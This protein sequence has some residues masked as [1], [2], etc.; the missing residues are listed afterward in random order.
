MATTKLERID[1]TIDSLTGE[2]LA[3]HTKIID[4][5]PMEQEPD[6]VKFYIEDMGRMMGL[7]D[8]H[9]SILLYVAASV[10][11][12]GTLSM[13]NYRKGRIACTLGCSKRSI[14]NAISE[15]VKQGILVRIAR[16]EY[17]LDPHLFARGRWV[18]IRQRRLK[19]SAKITYSPTTGRTIETEVSEDTPENAE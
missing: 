17:E 9:R 2:I 19:F 1:R 18:D 11:Y 5:K 3:E 8:G 10:S 15:F 6:Y 14:D 4:L 12:D 7:Q 16:G 13:T